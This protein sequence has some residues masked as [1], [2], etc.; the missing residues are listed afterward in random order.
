MLDEGV[1]VT[2]GSD[3]PVAP[4]DPWLAISAAVGRSRDGKE[5][6]HPE[7]AL[8]VQ[9]AL[10]ALVDGQPT[11]GPGSRGDLAVLDIDPLRASVGDLAAIAHGGVVLTTVGGRVVHRSV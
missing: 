2:L 5:P 7:Q 1:R 3:A 6:W 10:A 9:E 4:L 8:T 11:V